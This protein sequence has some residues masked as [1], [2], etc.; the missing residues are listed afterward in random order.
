MPDF[1]RSCD[2]RPPPVLLCPVLEQGK[3][4]AF[5]RVLPPNTSQEQVYEQCAKQIV[6]GGKLTSSSSAHACILVSW[7]VLGEGSCHSVWNRNI[8]VDNNS[9]V[10][11]ISLMSHVLFSSR[12]AGWLQWDH[13]RIWT[14]VL[15][16]DTH[17][18]GAVEKYRYEIVA[19][20]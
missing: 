4:Y 13:L 12:C 9:H 7:Q 18:G 15:R 1:V 8:T 16:E 6:K 19:Q 14:D 2:T 17:H 11:V 3:P 5:D 20:F 10:E